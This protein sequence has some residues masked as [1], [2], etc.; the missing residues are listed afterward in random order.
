M[1]SVAALERRRR[2]LAAAYVKATRRHDRRADLSKQMVKTTCAAL[3]ADLK[4]QRE[5]KT[6]VDDLFT[7]LKVHP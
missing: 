7:R 6:A 5:A 4:S 3:R 1:A 2:E